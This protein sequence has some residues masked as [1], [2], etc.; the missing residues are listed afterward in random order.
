MPYTTTELISRAYYLSGVLARDEQ[1]LSGTQ[2][3]DGLYLLNALLDIKTAN[4]RLIPYYRQENFVGEVG[5]QKYFIENLVLAESLTF[6]LDSVR[7]QMTQ[8]SRS[9]FFETSR[10]NNINSLPQIWHMER[11]F[12]GADIY[13]YFTPDHAY[14]F[15][16][17]GKFALSDVELGQN[18]S[19]TIDKFYIEYL[20]NALADSICE[21]NQISTP[22]NVAIRLRQ[23]EKMIFDISPLDLTVKKQ[24]I[25]RKPGGP[26]IY[27]QVNI[28][29]AWTTS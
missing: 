18:L 21:E 26:D 4:Q 1:T 11:A 23:L 10:A 12:G 15:Q 2:Q 16:L 17:W 5:E 9:K 7:Y 6:T 28:G 19:E 14:D 25:L 20:R 29:G 8:V 27:A 3:A 13:M 22:P 24:S